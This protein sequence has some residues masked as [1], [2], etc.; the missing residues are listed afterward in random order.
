MNFRHLETCQ[1]PEH[2]TLNEVRSHT[3]SSETWKC[4]STHFTVLAC[5]IVMTVYCNSGFGHVLSLR[6]AIQPRGDK[7]TYG[8]RYVRYNTE[9]CC[10]ILN[11]CHL[12][13]LSIDA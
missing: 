10:L 13:T 5:L 4:L 3:G 2:R 8:S 9:Q 7:E 12:L 6:M 11:I 1:Y